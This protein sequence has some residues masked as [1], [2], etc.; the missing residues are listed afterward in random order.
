LWCGQRRRVSFTSN[1]MVKNRKEIMRRAFS[2]AANMTD[3]DKL[4]AKASSPAAR[5]EVARLQQMYGK[6]EQEAAG[7]STTVPPIDFQAFKKRLDGATFVDEM[8]KA[9]K[10]LEYPVG[11]NTLASK[12]DAKLSELFSAAKSTADQ[13]AARA[14]ELEAFLATLQKNRTTKDTTIEDVAALYPELAA[15]VQSEIKKHEWMKGVNV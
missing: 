2:T 9:Y 7:L 3:W 8:E 13:S 11:T 14:H 15:E 4:L 6:V 1:E 5:S 10:Q 12:A